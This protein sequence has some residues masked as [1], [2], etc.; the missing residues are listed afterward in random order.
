LA[1]YKESFAKY[2]SSPEELQ[3]F[4]IYANLKG[5]PTMQANFKRLYTALATRNKPMFSAAI[6]QLCEYGVSEGH[7][8]GRRLAP[9]PDHVIDGVFDEW[10]QNQQLLNRLGG[11]NP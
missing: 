3:G 9:L 8:K 5:D 6:D 2:F 1:D 11:V 10:D 7:L 4:L